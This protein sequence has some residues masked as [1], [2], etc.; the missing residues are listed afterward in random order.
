MRTGG[1]TAAAPLR[2]CLG[3]ASTFT[4]MSNA[5]CAFE[6]RTYRA[7]NSNPQNCAATPAGAA[8]PQ[9]VSSLLGGSKAYSTK[10]TRGTHAAPSSPC[11]T[12][13][14]APARN[15]ARGAVTAA[16]QRDI[17]SAHFVCKIAAERF[18]EPHR[19]TVHFSEPL[20]PHAAKVPLA[21]ARPALRSLT[22]LRA[23]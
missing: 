3:Q 22:Y 10:F 19:R 12:Q 2:P 8:T 16:C 14:G 1:T 6:M 5:G 4:V 7:T 9:A 20:P 11:S 23:S 18:S 15:T 21:G 13:Q 17:L